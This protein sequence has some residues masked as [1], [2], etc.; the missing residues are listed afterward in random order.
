MSPTVPTR[1][2]WVEYVNSLLFSEQLAYRHHNAMRTFYRI[3]QIWLDT[4]GLAPPQLVID[5]LQI[6]AWL[7][8]R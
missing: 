5:G 6:Y 2:Q 1:K 4:P 3:W 7:K 8:W